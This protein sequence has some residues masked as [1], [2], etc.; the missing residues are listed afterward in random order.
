MYRKW[1][2]YVPKWTCTELDLNLTRSADRRTGRTNR[3]AVF[4][5]KRI[6]PR[7]FVENESANQL[8]L[9]IGMLQQYLVAGARSIDV[10]WWQRASCSRFHSN[11][12]R[13]TVAIFYSMIPHYDTA[14]S[15]SGVFR[16]SVR[17]RRGDLGVVEW[18]VVEGLGPSTKNNDLL[19]RNVWNYLPQSVDFSSLTKFKQSLFHVDFSAYVRYM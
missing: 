5:P 9:Q 7:G 14:I 6:D 1:P 16:I 3:I 4:F 13:K 19:S 17:R 18:D 8:E 15:Y 12:H 2:P 11:D 10:T